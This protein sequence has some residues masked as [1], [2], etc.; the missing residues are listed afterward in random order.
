M[1]DKESRPNFLC[2]LGGCWYFG[3]TVS[4]QFFSAFR[5]LTSFRPAVPFRNGSMP[6]YHILCSAALMVDVHARKSTRNTGSSR[7][8][9]QPAFEQ[10]HETEE[11]KVTPLHE[12]KNLA[13]GGL[14]PGLKRSWRWKIRD[15]ATPPAAE[16]ALLCLAEATSDVRETLECFLIV[17]A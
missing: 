5:G 2:L 16:A 4:I 1:I 13:K 12:G 15:G 10:S 14:L 7:H 3:C 8:V 17:A 11:A 9:S 6:S